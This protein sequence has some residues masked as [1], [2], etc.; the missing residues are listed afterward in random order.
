MHRCNNAYKVFNYGAFEEQLKQ[1]EEVHGV[2]IEL[3]DIVNALENSSG[4]GAP[5]QPPPHLR[6]AGN[7][8]VHRGYDTEGHL[9]DIHTSPPGETVYIYGVD[10]VLGLDGSIQN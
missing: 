1:I 5:E 8:E 2:H 3:A 9:L 4:H 6:G 7:I 10:Y